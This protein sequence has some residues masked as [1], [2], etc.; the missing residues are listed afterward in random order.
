M[1]TRR[2]FT[3][4]ELLVVIAIIGVL[5]GLLLPAVQKVRE[6]A[7][8][9]KCTNNLKQFGLAAAN[10]ENTYGTFP[11]GT[12]YLPDLSPA[13]PILFANFTGWQ[14]ALLPYLEQD[15]LAKLYSSAKLNYDPTNLLVLGNKLSVYSCPSDP[16]AGTTFTGLALTRF[17]TYNTQALIAGS[18]KGVE[19][20]YSTPFPGVTLFWDYGSYVA[21][22]SMEAASRGPLTVT[23]K[24]S[25]PAY[26]NVGPV[27]IAEV[28]DGTS[29]TFLIGEYATLTDV[30][31]R[32]YWGVS[33]GYFN[34]AACGPDAAVRGLPNHAACVKS[35]EP[36]NRCNRAFASMHPGGMNFVMCDGSV[37][38]SRPTSTRSCTRASPPSR[39]EK[40]ALAFEFGRGRGR[41]SCAGCGGD[42]CWPRAWDVV[43]TATG[44]PRCRAV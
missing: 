22:L 41:S 35:G 37:H 14:E 43:P 28:L 27:R 36:A 3:L 26:N 33:W 13:T 44:S 8:R 4:I 9:M 25:N 38:S 31:F 5:I 17:P 42:C 24:S 12:E 1:R 23:I 34:L 30:V 21:Y 32:A 2:G 19:G 20:R 7:N 6:A 29:N 15:N 39:A 16:G 10:Y 40:S 18:Y 11:A